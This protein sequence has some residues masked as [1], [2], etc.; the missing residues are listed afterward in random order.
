MQ[1]TIFFNLGFLTYQHLFYLVIILFKTT[2]IFRALRWEIFL[3]TSSTTI[4]Q[5]FLYFLNEG[6]CSFKMKKIIYKMNI[7]FIKIYEPL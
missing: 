4:N 2:I 6:I 1:I 3:L 5:N 7:K